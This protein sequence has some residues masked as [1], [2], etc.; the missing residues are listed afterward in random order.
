MS[1]PFEV[2]LS[3]LYLISGNDLKERSLVFIILL[4]MALLSDCEKGYS[5]P[6]LFKKPTF[7]DTILI[8]PVFV[9]G[10][11]IDIDGEALVNDNCFDL[12][13]RIPYYVKLHK[14]ETVSVKQTGSDLM[15]K[16]NN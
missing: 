11:C 10:V 2:K 13:P 8:S 9:W 3:N 4:F 5:L 12:F 1:K 6:V 16:L 7:M 15:L 14:G